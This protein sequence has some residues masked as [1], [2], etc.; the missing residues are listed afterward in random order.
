MSAEIWTQWA[1]SSRRGSFPETPASGSR[2][3]RW[4][5]P[6]F[7]QRLPAS[8]VRAG[9][10]LFSSGCQLLFTRFHSRCHGMLYSP[11][12]NISQ[13]NKN[14]TTEKCVCS[15]AGT[16]QNE[17]KSLIPCLQIIT[18]MFLKRKKVQVPLTCLRGTNDHNLQL[19]CWRTI[20]LLRCQRF[21]A[22]GGF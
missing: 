18:L 9:W 5:L 8:R 1:F 16:F 2:S 11:R 21:L 17:R 4:R 3:L 13:L 15:L 7:L 14:K 22:S 19:F 20:E 12:W 6:V 10:R